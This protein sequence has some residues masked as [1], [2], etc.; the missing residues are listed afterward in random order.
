MKS[1]HRNIK[2]RS[3]HPPDWSVSRCGQ[4]FICKAVSDW[5][6]SRTSDQWRTLSESPDYVPWHSSSFSFLSL[7]YYF[8][9]TRSLNTFIWVQ[10]LVICIPILHFFIAFF[11]QPFLFTYPIFIHEGL[12]LE[13]LW[14]ILRQ[15]ERQH[16]P[17][18]FFLFSLR[19]LYNLT[20]HNL[21]VCPL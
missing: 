1:L 15:Q 10:F 4:M 3:Y 12:S 21:L 13:M 7:I 19:N 6:I 18:D 5:S 20:C 11:L 2:C 9:N 16:T 14:L 17:A 8:H